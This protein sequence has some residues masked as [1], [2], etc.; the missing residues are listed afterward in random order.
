VR[1]RIHASGIAVA[2]DGTLL[3]NVA[4][5]ANTQDP[6][7]LLE[8]AIME[9]GE[10]FVGVQ[11]NAREAPE[12]WRLFDDRAAEAAGVIGGRR[13]RRRRGAKERSRARSGS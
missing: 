7:A 12:I 4:H 6:H 9:G 3:A 8:R 5:W 11:V 10:L 2:S 13:H 1:P